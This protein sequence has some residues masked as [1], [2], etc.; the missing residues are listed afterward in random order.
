MDYHEK[1]AHEHTQ[2]ALAGHSDKLM[3]VVIKFVYKYV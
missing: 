3:N 1:P 2:Q